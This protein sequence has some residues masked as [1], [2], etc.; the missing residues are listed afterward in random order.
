MLKE[1]DLKLDLVA[2]GLLALTVFLAASLLSYDPADPPSKLVYP[3]STQ[4]A[5]LCGRSGALVSM[6]LLGAFGLGGYYVLF[7]LA[8]LD[9]LLLTRRT[10]TDPI[11]RLGGWLLSLSGISTF[12]AM[13]LP[14]LSPGPVI[15]SGGYL[16]AAGRGFLEVNFATVGAYIL[17]VSLILGGLLLCTDY[18]L[19]RI[20]A[21]SIGL[22]VKGVGRGVRRVGTAYSGRQRKRRS[23]LDQ[24]EEDVEEEEEEEEPAVRIA[25]RPADDETENDEEE[26]EEEAPEERKEE[27][28][29]PRR[30]E[31]RALLPLRIRKPQKSR[32]DELVEEIEAATTSGDAAD[33][34]LPAPDL[35][36]E[37]EPFCFDEHEQEVRRK[38]KILEKTFADFG[39]NIRVVEIQTGPVVAQFE[40]ALEAGLRLSKITGL[41]DDLAAG[42]LR[43]GGRDSAG[44]VVK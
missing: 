32:R 21:S 25:G 23:D 17:V 35:L 15:G 5:N 19:I 3:Q 44:A 7:S 31:R 30:P 39:F 18:M 38:A 16:G 2:L 28:G 20:L 27:A 6:W 29:S 8:V 22:P 13:A 9:S 40:V 34:E 37:T 10:I 11:L 43:V 26:Q 42:A 12:S 33:Y 24:A 41:A 14:E 1:R 4:T 36:L